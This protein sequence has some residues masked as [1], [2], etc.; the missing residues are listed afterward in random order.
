M[1]TIVPIGLAEQTEIKAYAD[2][3][4]AA[5]HP[6]RERLGIDERS[7]GSALAIVAVGEETRF[8]NR[9][10]GFGPDRPIDRDTVAEMCEFFRRQQAPSGMFMIAPSLLPP[11]WDSIAGTFGLT[12]GTRFVKLGLDIESAVAQAVEP[13]SSELRVGRVGTEQAHE[14]ATV[15]MP[16]LGHAM[17]DVIE[18]AEACVG[19][20]DW[21]QYAVWEGER[22][23]AV[24]S[25][26]VNGECADMFGGA[27]LEGWRGRGAQSA[28][29][30]ARVS[31]ARAAGCRWMV[32]EAFAEGPGEHNSSLHNML[33][34][35]FER[36]YERV[37]WVWQR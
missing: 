1:Q 33:S 8:F 19:R 37:S 25:I 22:I 29:L 27:T 4:A 36:M 7:V 3:L 32:A 21:Q 15:M 5:P 24:G 28:L 23:I 6:V 16:T 10:G 9:A 17:P 26:Y 31:A 11:D 13:L 30:A 20:P 12:E 14:W 35:G 18:M 34:T 2:F